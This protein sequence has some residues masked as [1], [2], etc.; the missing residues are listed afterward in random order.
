MIFY[1]LKTWTIH[2]TC[3]IMLY[4]P[5]FN[6]YWTK[7]FFANELGPHPVP[8]YPNGHRMGYKT[9]VSS[10]GWASF[11]LPWKKHHQSIQWSFG[12]HGM[13]GAHNLETFPYQ[14]QPQKRGMQVE[15]PQIQ[16]LV[17]YVWSSENHEKLATNKRITSHPMSVYQKKLRF[18]VWN[19]Y[20]S[21][22]IDTFLVGWT[23]IYQLFW[24][25]LGTRVLTH[26]QISANLPMF[27]SPKL[28]LRLQDSEKSDQKCPTSSSC[29]SSESH[30]VS[31][32]WKML[33]HQPQIGISPCKM[34]A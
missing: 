5:L 9:P 28:L 26:P 32:P 16:K 2:V 24:G 25:S 17:V 6:P 8:W 14:E 10:C 19:G 4:S 13:L 30:R 34:V 11:Q 27:P 23:S 12:N 1:P 22:P 21:I 18:A 20:G 31:C 7:S 33:L 29:F 15:I 3:Y